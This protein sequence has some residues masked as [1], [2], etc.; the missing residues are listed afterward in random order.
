[1]NPQDQSDIPS[2]Q[3]EDI[4]ATTEQ[5]LAALE[6]EDTGVVA[7][8]IENSAIITPPTDPVPSVPIDTPTPPTTPPK[9]SSKKLI[10]ILIVGV[11]LIA[12]AIAG[13]FFWQSSQSAVTPQPTQTIST[14]T[15]GNTPGGNDTPANAYTQQSLNEEAT[16]IENQVNAFDDSE[17]DDSTLSDAALNQ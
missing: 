13:Y 3:D 16:S 2:I 12:A 9:K 10:I 4:D 17:Y 1:M 15:G 5:T 11:I 14:P 6:A 7:Q 8:A